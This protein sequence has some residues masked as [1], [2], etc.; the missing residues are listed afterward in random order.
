MVL[1]ALG[2]ARPYLI[3]GFLLTAPTLVL[4]Y[5]SLRWFGPIGAFIHVRWAPNV[6]D[7]ERDALELR[8][9]LTAREVTEGTT[10]S[11]LLVDTS[12]E[13][14]RRLIT[15]PAVQDTHDLNRAAFGVA[16]TAVQVLVADAAAQAASQQTAAAAQFLLMG[17]ALL[18][19]TAIVVAIIPAQAARVARAPFAV[20]RAVARGVHDRIPDVSP[21]GAALF[22]I[23]FGSAAVA[24]FALSPPA[25][26]GGLITT[27]LWIS[28]GLFVA[29]LLTRLSFAAFM[30]GA[31]AWSVVYTMESGHHP[32][33]ALLIALLCL[34]PARWGDAWSIDALLRRRCAAPSVA[35]GFSR[36]NSRD[37]GY[38]V[39]IPGVVLGIALA[40]AAV[41]KLREGGIG[42][43]LNG[44][45]KYHFLTDM[46]NAPVDW[47][48]QLG[49]VPAVAVVLSFAAIAVES[50]VIVAALVGP[51]SVRLAAA[52]AVLPMFVGFWLFQGVFWPAWWVLLLSFA[53]WHRIRSDA[54]VRSVRLQRLQTVPQWRIAHAALLVAAIGQQLAASTWH[55]EIPPFVSAYDM[56][57]KT[58]AS[59]AEYPPDGGYSHWLVGS[60]ADQS[61]RSCRIGGDEA[62]MFASLPA[63]EY[64]RIA[65]E[66]LAS[67]FGDLRAVRTV[68]VDEMRPNVDWA[69]GRYLG[70]SVSRIS[71]PVALAIDEER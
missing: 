17:V 23:V 36:T 15:H 53:P 16:D 11:Y 41:S 38:T 42:W 45:V 65:R 34:L 21:E 24:V 7:V 5:A 9:C 19:V 52:L 62:K 4:D 71:G 25:Q 54:H 58:Y 32:I 33:S 40:A 64:A 60:L 27:W 29:G 28:G 12:T 2:R 69:A 10:Y 6:D 1:A 31:V 70:T 63:S 66:M 48:V 68:T 67:C 14:I 30:L 55:L 51:W 49:V 20:A 37:Y 18:A 43:I 50:L 3:A 59:P 46:A 13:N 8:F 44:T 57:S 47:G 26:Y 61:T 35:S 22:R 56:Y 39:W